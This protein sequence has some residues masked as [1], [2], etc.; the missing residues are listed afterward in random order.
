[1]ELPSKEQDSSLILCRE[2]VHISE[3]GRY[4]QKNVMQLLNIRLNQSSREWEK[5]IIRI[6]QEE[7]GM[8]EQL[9]LS[10]KQQ[11]IFLSLHRAFCMCS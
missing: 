4:F 7:C 1:M 8:P 9:L 10:S 3:I 2:V 6:I 11:C 5:S